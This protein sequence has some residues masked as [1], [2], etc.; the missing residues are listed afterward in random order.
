MF[1]MIV[2]IIFMC[3]CSLT[4]LLSVNV[5]ASLSISVSALTFL[6]FIISRPLN[7]VSV[8]DILGVDILLYFL[9]P[10]DLYLCSDLFYL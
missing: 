6:D 7:L 3:P 10:L 1:V 9:M 2:S 5:D 8:S 4:R